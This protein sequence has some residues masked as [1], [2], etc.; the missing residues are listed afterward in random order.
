MKF[1]DSDNDNDDEAPEV[2]LAIQSK[3]EALEQERAIKS[4]EAK[5]KQQRK[6]LNRLRDQALKR[7]AE[8]TRGPSKKAKVLSE[9]DG[10]SPKGRTL[11]SKAEE[12]MRKAMGEATNEDNEEGSLSDGSTRGVEDEEE[13]E[14]VS[15]DSE[16]V[17]EDDNED[18]VS[19]KSPSRSYDSK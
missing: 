8:E 4:S 11:R 7:R 16:D 12:R 14:G 19:A 1:V 18:S 9:E 15:E 10:P 6:E 5:F 3:A 17:N 2:V 13:F